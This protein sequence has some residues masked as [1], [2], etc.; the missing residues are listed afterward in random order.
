[1]KKFTKQKLTKEERLFLNN[2]IRKLFKEVYDGISVTNLDSDTKYTESNFQLWGSEDYK[3]I[4][5]NIIFEFLTKFYNKQLKKELLL[6]E[7]D[8][9]PEYCYDE[10]EFEGNLY[11]TFDELYDIICDIVEKIINEPKFKL[12]VVSSSYDGN[13]WFIPEY[14]KIDLKK[15]TDYSTTINNIEK[16]KVLEDYQTSCPV[17]GIRGFISEDKLYLVSDEQYNA[18]LNEIQ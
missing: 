1:M 9:L 16:L 2:V 6:D 13:L 10:T 14:G 17:Y 3:A 15:K 12:G 4:Y 7:D 5:N 8:E 11:N 18:I